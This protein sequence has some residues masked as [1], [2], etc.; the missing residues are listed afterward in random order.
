MKH[1]LLDQATW[2]HEVEAIISD[3]QQAIV[4]AESQGLEDV[5]ANV[6]I[7]NYSGAF[8]YS[9]TVITT[10]GIILRL[11]RYTEVGISSTD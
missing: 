3:Y 1:N 11:H 9:I 4:E 7:W 10:I 6:K 8:L 2:T 5:E